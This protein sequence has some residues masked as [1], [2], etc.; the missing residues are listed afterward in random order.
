LTVSSLHTGKIRTECD[1][2]PRTS[3][4]SR[5]PGKKEGGVKLLDI[6]EQPMGF[7]AAK[8]RKRQQDLE[9]AKRAAE[10]AATQVKIC[11]YTVLGNKENKYPVPVS[12]HSGA[13]LVINVVFFLRVAVP[14]L[15]KCEGE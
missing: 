6:T 14:F 1:R 10:E 4:P 15:D 3:L 8:K 12:C 5:Q 7:A 11:L 13:S 2:P 9:D